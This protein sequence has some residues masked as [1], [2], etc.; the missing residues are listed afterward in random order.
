MLKQHFIEVDM[1]HLISYNT[2]LAN[3]L[4]AQPAEMLPLVYILTQRFIEETITYDH[5]VRNS[6]QRV[7]KAYSQSKPD[8]GYWCTWLSS[9]VKVWRQRDSNSWSE[10]TSLKHTHIH[11]VTNIRCDSL[12]TLVNWYVYRVLSLVHRPWVREQSMS[13]SCVAHVAIR[14]PFPSPVD[15]AASPF[16]ARATAHLSTA[17]APTNVLWIHSSLSMTKVVSSI[18]KSWNYKRHPIWS[19]WVIFLVTLYWMPIDGSPI[20]WFLVCVWWLW[21][22]TPFSKTRHP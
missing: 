14:K 6:R 7:S 17:D 12:I 4:I 8:H 9:H 16:H 18:A 21:V 5:I 3:Q 13:I 19:P 10:R 15:S 1:G 2:D 20:A 11:I 22:F